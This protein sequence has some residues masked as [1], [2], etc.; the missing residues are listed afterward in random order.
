MP[1]T[2]YHFENRI[3]F[4]KESGIITR[5]DAQEWVG[6]LKQ[7]AET[8]ELPIVALVD[9]MEV[10]SV[11]RAAEQLF[12]EGAYTDNLLATNAVVTIQARTIHQMTRANMP[13]G[14]SRSI[15]SRRN[16]FYD[17]NFS[18]STTVANSP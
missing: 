8:S 17:S 6:R 12:I 10:N 4:A 3:F 16:N 7:L 14:S 1:I 9:A 15:R 18:V 5:E 11:L 2:G 13:N